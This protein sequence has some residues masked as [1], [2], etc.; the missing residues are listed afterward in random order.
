LNAL[1]RI[2]RLVDLNATDGKG[3]TALM[4]SAKTGKT[5][6]VEKL[7]SAGV[8]P[9]VKDLQGCT[10]LEIA[11]NSPTSNAYCIRALRGLFKG[12]ST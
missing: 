10:A 6:F 2:I 8:D 12:N 4:I 11:I 5:A 1:D 3:Q 9:L 7:I